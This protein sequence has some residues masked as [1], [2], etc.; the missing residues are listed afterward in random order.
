MVV[1]G[2]GVA[3]NIEGFVYVAMNAQHQA[4]MTFASQNYGAGKP[5]R[6]KR[7]LWCCL[8]IVTAIGLGMG[9]LILLFGAPLMSLYN[10]EADV[11]AC[12]LV[13]MGIIMPT[14]FI[15]GLMDVMVGQLRGV[16]YSIMPM[17]VSLTGACLL[18]IVWILTVFAQAHDLTVLY[19]SHPVSWFVTFAIHFLCYMLVARKRIDRMKAA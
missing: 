7:T 10:P 2:N 11:I 3:C 19:M 6:V 4:D 18:R 5:D 17:I 8:G 15:C 16:G 14:Y 13:R 12:G 1:A 9:L